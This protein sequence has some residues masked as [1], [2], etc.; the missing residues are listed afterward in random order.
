MVANI[1]YI[2]LASPPTPP[3]F[4]NGKAAPIILHQQLDGGAIGSLLGPS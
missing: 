4:R 2:I 3:Y 1:F